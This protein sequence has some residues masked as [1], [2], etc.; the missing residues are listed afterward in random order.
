MGVLDVKAMGP[1]ELAQHY[2]PYTPCVRL[3][4]SLCKTVWDGEGVR[5]YR[6]RLLT[7]YGEESLEW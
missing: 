7:L 4:S 2:T 1:V 5:R 3:A 6:R